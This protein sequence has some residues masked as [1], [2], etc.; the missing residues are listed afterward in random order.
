MR[1]RAAKG[2]LGVLAVLALSTTVVRAQSRITLSPGTTFQTIDGFGGAEMRY[3]PG[4]VQDNDPA[5]GDPAQVLY[6]HPLRSQFM[7]LAFSA[8]NGIGLTI[9]RT[10]ITA[11]LE[12]SDGNYRYD[13]DPAQTWIMQQ[14]VAQGPVKLF[15]SAMSPPAWMKSNNSIFGGVCANNSAM[16]CNHDATCPG[17]VCRIGALTLSGYPRFADYLLHYARDYAAFNGLS[18]YA[19]SMANEPEW[20]PT[21]DGSFWYGDWI[22]AFLDIYLRPAFAANPQ[23]TTKIV[24]PEAGD[25]KYVAAAV[26]P[27]PLD[28]GPNWDTPNQRAAPST[29]LGPTIN[30]ANALGRVDIVAGHEYFG[31]PPS[32]LPSALTTSGKRT[33]MTEVSGA[34]STMQNALD[35]AARIHASLTGNAQAS[36]WLWFLMFG[37]APDSGGLV[38]SDSTSFTAQKTFYALGNFS[39]F[40]RPGFVRISAASNDSNLLPSAFK[41]PA[42]GQIVIVLINKSTSARTVQFAG[43][44][45]P[46]T[47]TPFVTCPSINL[48]P[49][50]DVTLAS[51]STSVSVP[52]QSIV[53]YVA[54]PPHLASDM[55]W[56]SAN[57]TTMAWLNAIPA[58]A[59]YPGAVS[60]DWQIQGI[61]DF[62]G[63]GRGDILWRSINGD[64]VIW[65]D[66]KAPGI[67]I[68]PVS[69]DWSV[70]GIGDFDH[71]GKSDILW[72]DI[73]GDNVIWPS[74]VAPGRWIAGVN[75]AWRVVGIGDFTGD[76]VSDILWRSTNGDNVIWPSGNAP[77]FWLSGLDNNWQVA[78][79]GDFDANGDA[80]ILWRCVPQ[81]PATACGSAAAG[82]VAIWQ[83]SNGNYSG[84][85]WPGALDANW[86]L[87]GVGD[88]DGS[89]SSDI[90][91]RCLPRAPATACGNASA[92]AVAIWRFSGGVVSSTAWP[93][94]LDS[95]WQLARVGRLD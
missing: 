10:K 57:G 69:T 61:G 22:A 35:Y 38:S 24:V 73:Y 18:I 36:A 82:T 23:I 19:I 47:F 31:E 20:A 5:Q 71:D 42:M 11:A 72:R 68:S 17:S 32:L 49:F 7:T 90:L 3:G 88:F 59:S 70:A 67:W 15:A 58:T 95:T 56:R 94:I 29:L 53:T 6:T 34:A 81:A 8:L 79:V 87:E 75:T 54:A 89:G 25:W 62:D 65:Y 28:T 80:D 14:A 74:G 2:L 21:W 9:L 52:A 26:P 64:N 13:N 1:H 83:F 46:I 45:Y 60:S 43:L 86:R 33:W 77:G 85:T 37:G 16:T 30:N 39:K 4:F 76:G 84:T 51:S 50:P 91:W 93:G 92:G 78:G 41:D 63:N 48:L 27:D 40:V 55:L 44:T 12:L 66:S